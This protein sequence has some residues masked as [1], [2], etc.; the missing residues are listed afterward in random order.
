M[1]RLNVFVNAAQL[2]LYEYEIKSHI[3]TKP[4]DQSKS[5]HRKSTRQLGSKY[6]DRLSTIVISLRTHDSFLTPLE[7][8]INI[9]KLNTRR[10]CPRVGCFGL[11]PVR[12]MERSD[13][14]QLAECFAL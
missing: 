9:F 10:S 8:S 4:N 1:K 3:A 5:L 14:F 13:G 11:A 6:E 12:Q 2:K 7:D